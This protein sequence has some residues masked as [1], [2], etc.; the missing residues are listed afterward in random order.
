[1]SM[2]LPRAK[3]VSELDKFKDYWVGRAGQGG[4]KLDWEATWRN[5]V[6]RALES[7]PEADRG[8]GTDD[9]ETL[10]GAYPNG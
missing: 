6:R 2:G 4:V 1:M 10:I 3:A 7:I 8:K 9:I 5:W